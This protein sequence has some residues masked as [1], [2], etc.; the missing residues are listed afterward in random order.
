[1]EAAFQRRSSGWLLL[2][3]A[4]AGLACQSHRE[5]SPGA[6][7]GAAPTKTRSAANHPGGAAAQPQTTE[8]TTVQS[9]IAPLRHPPP[10]TAD[11]APHCPPD[12]SGRLDLPVAAV[13]FDEAPGTPTVA[14]ELANDAL[15][16][17]R[18]LM[19]RTAMPTDAGMLFTF[20]TQEQR[21]FWMRNTCIPLD[22]LF[23][24]ADSSIVGILEQ[25]PTLNTLPRGVPCPSLSVLELNAGWTRAHGVKPGQKVTVTR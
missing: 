2:A 15:A 14:V 25:V 9:C 7:P 6:E 12:P 11:P 13:R 24:D 16:R 21:S 20:P 23:L 4:A 18:G 22:I 10:P 17:R 1:M 3:A 19:Y 8:P 5:Q